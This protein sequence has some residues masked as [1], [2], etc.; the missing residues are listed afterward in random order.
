[1][2]R[3]RHRSY[4]TRFWETLLLVLPVLLCPVYA[5]VLGT[6]LIR[7]YVV[8]RW[9]T[10]GRRSSTTQTHEGGD[11]LLTCFNR[12]VFSCMYVWTYVR[13]GTYIFL[14]GASVCMKRAPL[15]TTADS[16]SHRTTNDV[17]HFTGGN[18]FL[19]NYSSL[20]YTS[21]PIATSSTN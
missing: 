6:V 15:T 10:D 4:H 20:N 5:G 8:L 12:F 11:L 18:R 13:T 19:S 21:R 2:S 1:M 3:P 9:C 7:T 14:S 16:R 17:T